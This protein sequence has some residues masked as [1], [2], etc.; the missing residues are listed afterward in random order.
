MTGLDIK[1]VA[2][3]ASAHVPGFEGPA[4]AQQVSGG[5]SNP[6]YRLITR[7]K[8]YVLRRKPPG[9]LL[10]SAHAVDREFIVFLS[11]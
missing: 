2:A 10:K 7:Q 3:W 1:A 6:T 5:Q 8:A 9:V 4:H 11:T